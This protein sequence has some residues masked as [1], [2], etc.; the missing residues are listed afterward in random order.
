MR[1]I[2]CLSLDI[3]GVFKNMETP[4]FQVQAHTKSCALILQ[5]TMDGIGN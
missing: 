4:S 5:V 2:V 3:L 1:F